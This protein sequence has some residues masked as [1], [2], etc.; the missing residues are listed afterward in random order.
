MLRFKLSLR[1]FRASIECD[2]DKITVVAPV[3]EAYTTV[4]LGLAAHQA[5]ASVI[6]R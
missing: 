5:N 4:K 6:G 2:A 1:P 3:T